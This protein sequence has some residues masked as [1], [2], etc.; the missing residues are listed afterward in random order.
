[1]IRL[2]NITASYNTTPIFEGL[3]LEIKKGAFMGI[4]GPSGIGKSTILRIIAG[5]LTPLKGRVDINDAPL[6][7]D[8]EA[9]SKEAK[10]EIMKDIGYIFQDFGLFP[11]MSVLQNLQIVNNDKQKIMDVLEQFKL[12]DRK[13]AYPD[14]L[15][16]GQKQRVAIARALMLNPKIL[17]IDEATSSLDAK[18]AYEFMEYMQS[19]NK[20]GMTLVFITHDTNLVDTYCSE[21]ID[22][23]QQLKNA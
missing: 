22:L 11:N 16:G 6:Y 2:Q 13:D 14:E 21:K 3:D 17:L 23:V 7:D 10:K 19:L 4:V 12:L 8:K 1:M 18:L 9:V 15:S 5:L 20:M